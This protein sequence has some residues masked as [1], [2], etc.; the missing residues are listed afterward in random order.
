M[1]SNVGVLWSDRE[2]R[3]FP[4]GR[5][6]DLPF[7]T[8]DR[9]LGVGRLDVGRGVGSSVVASGLSCL[10]AGRSENSAL[11]P[12]LFLRAENCPTENLSILAKELVGSVVQPDEQAQADNQEPQQY[13]EF[14]F[15]TH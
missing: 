11:T 13:P 12:L 14:G 8:A 15:F 9:G 4:Y 10:P 3:G 2:T 1:T 7:R 5:R 6:G